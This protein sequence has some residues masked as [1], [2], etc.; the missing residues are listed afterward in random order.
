MNNPSSANPFVPKQALA[1]TP[2]LYDDLVG[3]SMQKLAATTWAHLS[4]IPT[5]STI[6]DNGCGTGAATA[7][8]LPT[9]PDGTHVSIK[10]TDVNDA[11]LDIYRANAVQNKWPAEAQ[12]MDASA[13]SFPDATF[14]HSIG[15]AL[16][17]VLPDDGIP[18]VKEMYRTL[19]PG[20]IAALNSWAY[21]PNMEPVQAAARATR[22]PGTP[23]PRQGMRKWED[24]EFLKGVLV[25]GGFEEE[26]VEVRRE[27]VFVSATVGVERF[28]NMLWSFVGGTGEEGWAVS[29]EGNWE[30][31]IGVVVEELGKTEGFAVV[32]GKVRLRFVANVAVAVK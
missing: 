26:K 8:L 14:S 20:G 31:A 19:R 3:D 23:V 22:P 6:H 30:R 28:A 15:N 18:A 5:G 4:P 27:E 11:A 12:R 2:Q 17:F 16:L 21:V 7:A 13:L 25:K 1:P 10:A 24:A 29:D 9:L 32:E